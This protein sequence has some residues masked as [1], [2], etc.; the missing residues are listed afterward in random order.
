MRDSL[1]AK[2]TQ[3]Q[4]RIDEIKLIPAS[5]VLYET[6]PRLAAALADLAAALGPREVAVCRELTKLYEEVRRGDLLELARHYA[7][8]E[9]PRGEIVIVIGPPHEAAHEAEDLDS[10]LR[11]A[12]RRVS[13]K[14]AV[15]EIAAVT[16]EP[17]RAVYQRALALVEKAD[18]DAALS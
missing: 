4:K 5:L 3:R 15:A 12:L 11:Q 17:R 7:A 10:L 6:G 16:G 14:E 13:V 2:E 9:A 8:S 18:D 1:P